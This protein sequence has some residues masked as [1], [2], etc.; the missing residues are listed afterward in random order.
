MMDARSASASKGGGTASTLSSSNMDRLSMIRS[1]MSKPRAAPDAFDCDELREE[2]DG[3]LEFKQQPSSTSTL[4]AQR[5]QNAAA[6]SAQPHCPCGSG[7]GP[8]VF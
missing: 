8:T 1:S 2:R 6:D 7:R 4:D 3:G 5:I